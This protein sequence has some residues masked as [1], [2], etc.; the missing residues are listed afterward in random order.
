VLERLDGAEI[1]DDSRKQLVTP[2]LLKIQKNHTFSARH[3]QS[4]RRNQRGAI[5]FT[6]RAKPYS[7]IL[8]VP[9]RESRLFSGP[10]SLFAQ[11]RHDGFID[12]ITATLCAW[13]TGTGILRAQRA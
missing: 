10:A 5:F 8:R 2:S 7:V 1:L 13:K 11:I 6:P 3:K 4:D 12:S 9:R